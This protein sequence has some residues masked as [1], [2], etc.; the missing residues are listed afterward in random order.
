MCGEVSRMRGP[1]AAREIIRRADQQA[2]HLTEPP[3]HHARI[4]KGGDAQRQ[5]EAA[6]D[7]VDRL[8]ARCRSIEI[9]G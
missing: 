9:S 6:A 3:R 8:I 7:Q 1:P 4:R 5:V 2:P